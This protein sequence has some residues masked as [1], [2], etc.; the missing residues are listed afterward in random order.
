MVEMDLNHQSQTIVLTGPTQSGKS[1][2]GNMLLGVK[3]PQKCSND[4]AKDCKF[5]TG[6]YNQQECKSHGE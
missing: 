3:R 4:Q 2:L 1:Y 6:K 5:I